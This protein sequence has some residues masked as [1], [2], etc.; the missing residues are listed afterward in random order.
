MFS[1]R[2]E[3]D[4]NA[5]ARAL[6]SN[7]MSLDGEIWT[8]TGEDPYLLFDLP[9]P[10]VRGP[11]MLDLIFDCIRGPLSPKIYV[12]ERNGSIEPAAQYMRRVASNRY[13]LA[14]M[15]PR[16]TQLI[17]L[18]PADSESSF[19]IASFSAKPMSLA[20]FL[21]RAARNGEN[22]TPT[23]VAD[24]ENLK[25]V[26]ARISRGRVCFE[27]GTPR[28]R[29]SASNYAHW[30]DNVEVPSTL[31]VEQRYRSLGKKPLI[32]VIMP[33]YDTPLHTLDAA[34]QSV[35][36][37]LYTN[38]QL[39]IADDASTKHWVRPALERWAK[40][41]GRINVAFRDRKGHISEASNTAFSNA[42]GD[43]VALLGHRDVLGRTALAEVALAI[44]DC[45]RAELIYSDEDKLNDRAVRYDP[46]FKPDWSYD[47]F[48]G[49]N[50][51]NH[52]T[53]HRAENV[54][55][56]GGWRVGFEGSQDYDLDLRVIE[57][58]DQSSIVHIPRVLYHRR[59]APSSV[60]ADETTSE[61]AFEAGHRALVEHV[62]RT[63]A[64]AEVLPIA[65]GQYYR[66]R[67]RLPENPP[68]VSLIVP[69]R[70]K[71]AMLRTCVDSIVRKSDYSNY[72]IVIVDNGSVEQETFDYFGTLADYSNVRVLR[73]DEPFNYSAINNFAMG[74]ANG[75]VVGLV[76]NDIEVIN[77]D[78]LSE[79]VSHTLRP[80]VGC[81]GAK[82]YYPN[83]SLQHA[84]V[85]LGLSTIARHSHKYFDR[86]S[87]GYYGRLVLGQNLSAV[88][89]AC[90]LVR[91]EVY[92]AAGGFDEKNLAVAFNDVDFCLRVRQ[93][94]Y[95]NVWTPFAE[96]YHHE[97]MS[98]GSDNVAGELE[99]LEREIAY[100][101]QRWGSE[102]QE[103]PYYSRNLTQELEDF[104]LP[105]V[106]DSIDLVPVYRYGPGGSRAGVKWA[107]ASSR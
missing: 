8:S 66:L 24:F 88:T 43:W 6:G 69:T 4:L 26:A 41:D 53:V 103:D 76:N 25:R 102:L 28:S 106:S 94:G 42:K 7:Q 99:R 92:L 55:R 30:I 22:P 80:E 57:T 47:L 38:W 1:T 87:T 81:V 56:V 5:P 48:V 31:L 98:R 15:A 84:G 32:S 2:K 16:R 39:C 64:D 45:P 95:L 83:G 107:A 74:A 12:H 62:A 61:Y 50:Y 27:V 65:G 19:R 97:S 104:S 29:D 40:A 35:V 96:L 21:A 49:Q 58:I 72:E 34:I 85:I 46:H 68:L 79:M 13:K 82:L 63:N 77:H 20:A 67:R 90:L 3:I 52:L 33:V 9:G 91:K 71:A 75:E 23:S 17:R 105:P 93:R 14:F 36:T 78:W 73:Y 54:R 10:S 59:V 86:S 11:W 18:D 44:N 89:A 70:D 101:K 51:L 37:Q 100:M 60:A